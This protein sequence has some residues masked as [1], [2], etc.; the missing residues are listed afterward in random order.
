MSINKEN[1]ID[2]ECSL[3]N[4]SYIKSM[5]TENDTPK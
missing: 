2:I 1:H 5:D 3:L 4:K